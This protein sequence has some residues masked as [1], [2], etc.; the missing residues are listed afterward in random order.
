M[1]HI[2]PYSPIYCVCCEDE[3]QQ[4]NKSSQFKLILWPSLRQDQLCLH[5][6]NRLYLPFRRRSKQ[7]VGRRTVG[8]QICHRDPNIECRQYAHAWMYS[9]SINKWFQDAYHSPMGR[10]LVCNSI[11]WWLRL[12]LRLITKLI[13]CKLILYWWIRWWWRWCQWR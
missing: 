3:L 4:Y 5:L 11:V 2:Q 13:S 1:S 9:Q 7:S 8:T 12:W 6:P 10:L